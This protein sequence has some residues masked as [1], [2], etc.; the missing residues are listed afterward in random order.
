MLYG[1]GDVGGLLGLSILNSPPA[2][3]LRDR[4]EILGFRMEEAGLGPIELR[5]A[6]VAPGP[7]GAAPAELVISE[8]GNGERF[9]R[10]PDAPPATAQ[11]GRALVGRYRCADLRADASIAFEG[12]QLT[13][14]MRT[15]EGQRTASLQALSNTV[16]GY[17]ALDPLMPAFHAL[18]VER[19][20]SKITGFRLSS[21]R[22]RRLH[23]VRLPDPSTS[24][25]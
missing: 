8:A 14:R 5:R 12:E 3:I 15:P 22:A 9:K 1:F 10:L 7:D 11:A 23:F 6:D 4:G 21:A 18:T 17:S 25:A 20:A 24:G 16:F 19:Q 2:P 13:L